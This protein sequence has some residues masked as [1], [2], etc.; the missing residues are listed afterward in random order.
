MYV[1][2][3]IYSL[4][5]CVKDAKRGTDLDYVIARKNPRFTKPVYLE[6]W[7]SEIISN[8]VF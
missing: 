5:L 4:L 7:V 8:I 3:L 1:Y 6:L 2:I